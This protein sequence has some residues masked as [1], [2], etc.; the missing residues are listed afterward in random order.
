MT[1]TNDE[2]IQ[3]FVAG[4]TE[5]KANRMAISER[6]EWTFLWGY[7][8]A[9]YGARSPDGTLYVYDGW[10]GRSQT[11]STHMNTLKGKAKKRYGDPR[12]K[13]EEIRAVI[14]GEGGG[15]IVQTPAE[16]HELLIPTE[17]RPATSWG[18]FDAEGR[19][20][21]DRFDGKHVASPSGYD[22]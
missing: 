1:Y 3:R 15:S 6:D 17:A 18:T 12:A 7:G 10:Q 5:G 9:L 16:G 20:E 13:G 2:V 14:D 21:L 19:P 11:T 4:E 8:H 22:G